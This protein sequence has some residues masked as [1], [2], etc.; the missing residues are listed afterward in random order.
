MLGRRYW[1][2]WRSGTGIW[3]KDTAHAQ[4]ETESVGL[5]DRW[6]PPVMHVA[7]SG[8]TSAR[9]TTK[10]HRY[11]GDKN[12]TRQAERTKSDRPWD[13]ADSQ[14]EVVRCATNQIRTLTAHVSQKGPYFRCQLLGRFAWLPC[15]LPTAV[16]VVLFAIPF[17][18][19]LQ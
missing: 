17:Y 16:A 9:A 2:I 6:R 12:V 1:N 11:E 18:E 15:G 8:N 19:Q 13:C 5:W 10:W 7:P 14:P 4:N 3:T